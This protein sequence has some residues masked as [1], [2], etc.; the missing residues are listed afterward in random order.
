MTGIIDYNA[1]NIRSVERALAFLGADYRVSRRPQ[2]L[3]GA[4]RLIFPGVGEAKFAMGELRRNNF[5]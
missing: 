2:D 1:G 5:V 4:D 3:E